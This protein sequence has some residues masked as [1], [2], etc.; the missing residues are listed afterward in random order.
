MVLGSTDFANIKLSFN[1]LIPFWIS[2]PADFLQFPEL[3]TLEIIE[4]HYSSFTQPLKF[5]QRRPAAIAD[6]A[7]FCGYKP[8]NLHE[9]M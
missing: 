5:P 3:K 1:H 4:N 9:F 6:F 7:P 8:Y 2:Q